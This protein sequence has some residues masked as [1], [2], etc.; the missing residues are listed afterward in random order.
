MTPKSFTIFAIVTAATVVGAVAAVSLQPQPTSIPTNRAL[1]FPDVEPNLNRISAVSIVTSSRK[2]TI[3]RSEKA[4][5]IPELDDYPVPFEKVKT[6]LVDLSKLRFLEAKTSDPARYGRLEVEDLATKDAKST[7]VEVRDT[8]GKVLAA[9][10]IGKR[11]AS[12]FGADRGGTYVR[13][14]GDSRVWLAEGI[15]RLGTKPVDWV[16]RGIVD[17]DSED[18]KSVEIREPDGK[19]FF[20]RR[21]KKATEDFKLGTIPKGKAQRGQWETNQM[22]KALEKLIFDDIKLAR[23]LKFPGGPYVTEFTTFD[24]FKIRSEAAKLGKEY[25]VRFSVSADGVT[26]PDVEKTKKRAAAMNIR[27]SGYVYKVSESV[28]KRLACTLVNLLEGAGIKA[29][30]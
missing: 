23:D 8:G 1:V 27:V 14:D 17:L 19:E 21:E 20:I 28:G 24:G 22:P 9:G 16:A 15:I 25:W 13:K 5:I 6:A 4:W 10:I 26:G 29:C 12:V 18:V 2:I 11:N 7:H 3:K 30:A